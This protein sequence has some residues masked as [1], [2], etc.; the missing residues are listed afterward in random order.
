MT[1]KTTEK[2]EFKKLEVRQDPDYRPVPVVQIF[3]AIFLI[4]CALVAVKTCND[5]TH[6]ESTQELNSNR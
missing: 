1:F 2:N 3:F 6:I 4:A 5:P